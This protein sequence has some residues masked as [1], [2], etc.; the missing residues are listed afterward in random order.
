M[1]NKVIGTCS[2]CGGSVCVPTIW[3]GVYPPRPRCSRC[4][5]VAKQTGPVIEMEKPPPR[6]RVIPIP[7]SWRPG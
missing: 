2:L 3:H 7:W 5:A 1:S 6:P 4:G